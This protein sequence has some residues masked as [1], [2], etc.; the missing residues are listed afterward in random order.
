MSCA[1]N[2]IER[3]NVSRIT[4]DKFIVCF[5][6]DLN[7]EI[8]TFGNSQVIEHLIDELGTN[9]TFLYRQENSKKS[10]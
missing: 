1:S 4:Y 9:A 5:V 8:I 6:N 2:K 7:A 3:E 10:I